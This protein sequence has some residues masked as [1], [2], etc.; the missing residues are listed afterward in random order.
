MQGPGDTIGYCLKSDG[1]AGEC[2]EAKF[3]SP[4]RTVAGRATVLIDH[5]YGVHTEKK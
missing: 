3:A 5:R 4:P 1:H 2:G